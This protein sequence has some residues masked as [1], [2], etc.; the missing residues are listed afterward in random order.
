[1]KHGARLHRDLFINVLRLVKIVPMIKTSMPSAGRLAFLSQAQKHRYVAHLL[2]APPMQRG[3]CEVIEDMPPLYDVPLRFNL[4]EKIISA[5]L[6]PDK[7]TLPIS[8]NGNEGSLII[9]SFSCHCAV[10]LDYV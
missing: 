6:L 7:I 9:P 3:N 1:M 8:W 4:P 2:Y 5:R 10:S